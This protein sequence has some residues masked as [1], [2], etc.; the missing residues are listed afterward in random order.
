MHSS[1]WVAAVI[2]SSFAASALAVA[3]NVKPG[4]WERTVTRQMEG[5][6][7]SP[8]K[9]L[10][11]LPPDQR[12][13]IEEMLSTRGSTTPTTSV[14]RYCVTP[15]SAQNW[16]TFSRAERED[17]NCERTVRDETPRSLRMSIV[18]AGGK[19]TGTVEFA[20]AGPDRVT[21]TVI[22]VRQEERGERKVRIDMDSRWLGADC[23]D[24]KADAPQRVK[25]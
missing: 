23:G 12:A 3:P 19:G 5:T 9:D 13:R 7:V 14:A 8:V 24:V 4:L 11:K 20:A 15:E 22:F 2:A 17:A 10:S 25:G 16:D 18:C 6:P 1:R 21:G